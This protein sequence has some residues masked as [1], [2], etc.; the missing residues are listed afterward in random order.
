MST[1]YD[2]WERLVAAVLRR[3]LL[4]QICHDH[5]R[6]NSLISSLSSD[7][8]SLLIRSTSS[9]S[10][11]S[12]DFVSPKDGSFKSDPSLPFRF[13]A[14]CKISL[15][16]ERKE[17]AGQ[18]VHLKGSPFAFG[19]QELLMAPSLVLGDEMKTFRN[20]YI[21]RLKDQSIVFVVKRLRSKAR[22]DTIGSFEHENVVKLR[23]YY[24][25]GDECFGFYEYFP[26]GSVHTML[27]GKT[28]ENRFHL[29]WE[30]RIRI[31]VGAAKGLVHIHKRSRWTAH[32]N[33]KSSNIFL[34]SQ[35]Y[36]CISDIILSD[37]QISKYNPP[38]V[39]ITNK[40]SQASD[41]Y[42]FGVL[43]IELLSGRSP[44]HRHKTFVDWALHNARDE[45]TAMVFDTGLLRDPLAMQGMKDML[46]IALSCV[47]KQPHERPDMK[48]VLRKLE[49]M[50]HKFH[51]GKLEYKYP[52]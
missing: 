41:V 46:A 35:I 38:E 33:I 5:S 49:F 47:K 32:G 39:S 7:F 31:A 12:F 51:V 24:L 20:T 42:S 4:W 44:L 14:E 48:S 10:S 17:E 43:L 29:D 45:W 40:V 16:P 34:N 25:S 9:F 50:Y 11:A 8:S 1:I 22:L 15:T 13:L 3:E 6:T 26:R 37:F 28:G 23:G 19:L 21:V 2:N 52:R 18:L 30:T 36:G 27:H